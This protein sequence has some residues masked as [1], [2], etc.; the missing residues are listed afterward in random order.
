MSVLRLAAQ[1]K[2][3][4]ATAQEGEC[5]IP[6]PMSTKEATAARPAPV[7]FSTAAPPPQAPAKS[8]KSAGGTGDRDSMEAA[9]QIGAITT[10]SAPIRASAHTMAASG[11]PLP[12]GEIGTHPRPLNPSA[13]ATPQPRTPVSDDHNPQHQPP[14]QQS[15][16]SK[17]SCCPSSSPAPGAALAQPAGRLALSHSNSDEAILCN[18]DMDTAGTTTPADATDPSTTKFTTTTTTTTTA[19]ANPSTGADAATPAC[20]PHTRRRHHRHRH[21]H[22]RSRHLHR[23]P[24]SSPLPPPLRRDATATADATTSV[25]PPAPPQEGA[26]GDASGPARKTDACTDAEAETD[27]MTEGEDRESDMDQCMDTSSSKQG[28]QKQGEMNDDEKE[29]ECTSEWARHISGRGPNA[30]CSSSPSLFWSRYELNRIQAEA[31]AQAV[32]A[33]FTSGKQPLWDFIRLNSMDMQAVINTEKNRFICLNGGSSSSTNSN[34]DSNSR[35]G[36]CADKGAQLEQAGGSGSTIT[37]NGDNDNSSTTSHSNSHHTNTIHHNSSNSYSNSDSRK[38]NSSESNHSNHGSRPS[39]ASRRQRARATSSAAKH[40]GM[41]AVY[42]GCM[43]PDGTPHAIA[44]VRPGITTITTMPYGC[45][46]AQPNTHR[47]AEQP[48]PVMDEGVDAA[49][50]PARQADSTNYNSSQADMKE[51]GD[52]KLEEE[53][54]E[55]EKG[56]DVFGRKSADVDGYDVDGDADDPF[57]GEDDS[58]HNAAALEEDDDEVFGGDGGC[59]DDE[60]IANDGDDEDEDVFGADA[61]GSSPCVDGVDVFGDAEGDDADD[62]VNSDATCDAESAAMTA[63]HRSTIATSGSCGSSCASSPSITLARPLSASFRRRRLRCARSSADC[64]DAKALQQQQEQQQQQQTR[65]QQGGQGQCRHCGRARVSVTGSTGS[66][67]SGGGTCRRCRRVWF[68]PA[69]IQQALQQAT[70][71][72]IGD[73]VRAESLRSLEADLLESHRR[74][75]LLQPRAVDSTA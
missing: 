58:V 24:A 14:C 47:R 5:S 49:G 17:A 53:E 3:R 19:M 45:T 13:T 60:D 34:D 36:D 25:P 31:V 64:V 61:D 54:V 75:R 72:D 32:E 69:V 18:S 8:F 7:S 23:P 40:Q 65:Q 57:G 2:R 51:Q 48:A 28:E 20:H 27:T 71:Q 1:I 55:E 22:H 70:C 56:D 16:A 30:G 11:T 46:S 15:S 63:L 38:N 52:E 6:S 67:P 41:M 12:N 44:R 43:L 10:T 26:Q 62:V 4:I 50:T 74:M 35:F 37:P 42:Q 33:G 9:A 39:S 59:G 21:H 73:C 66:S 68:H 29:E